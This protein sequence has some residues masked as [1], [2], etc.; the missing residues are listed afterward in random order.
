M[1]RQ[2]SRMGQKPPCS[3]FAATVRRRWEKQ[4]MRKGKS[5]QRMRT[6]ADY[7]WNAAAKAT[8]NVRL[9]RLLASWR[10]SAQFCFLREM[11]QGDLAQSCIDAG[12]M[13]GRRLVRRVELGS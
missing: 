12:N 4:G 3:P 5:A 8:G 2:P 13:F 6:G 7:N 1:I 11:G 10:M 9:R